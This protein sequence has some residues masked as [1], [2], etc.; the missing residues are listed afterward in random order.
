MTKIS[1]VLPLKT[2]GR[3][4]AD[5][6]A[7]CDILFASLRR[8]TPPET[9]DRF[10]IIVPHDEFE[11]A[12]RYVRA[13]SDFPVEV[14]D[15]SIHM[16]AFAEFNQRHQIRPWHRQQIIKLHASELIDT[17]YFLVFDPDVFATHPFTADD[18]V[19]D[20]KALTYYQP[21]VRE[22]NMWRPSAGLLRQEP[23]L[24]RDGIWWTP[25]I[26]SRTLCRHLHRRLEEL[27]DR[28]WIR[29]LLANYMIDWTEYT[30]YWLN[31]ERE[32]LIDQFHAPMVPG[33]R[34]VHA[35]ESV[36]YA[37]K[38]GENLDLWQA[39][40]HFGED[41]DGLFAVVQSNTFIAPERVVEKLRPFFPITIQPYDRHDSLFLRSAEFYSAVARRGIK[42]LRKAW[43]G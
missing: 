42:F 6:I 33:R 37:G 39:E 24:E 13:W 17:E 14:V 8:F 3:H 4:Y 10:L 15:E 26:L 25:T 32:G 28:D 9:F 43:Q 35:S 34:S 2:R 27:Y 22:P 16:T 1:A 12:K 20:G 36:W 7:R 18:L 38:N 21:R 31:A 40:R 30:L 5:N 19:I 11:D 23:H 41:G 29:I